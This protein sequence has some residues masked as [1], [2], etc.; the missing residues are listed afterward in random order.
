MN[1][2][3]IL[4]KQAL[5][6]ARQIEV[7]S[8][9]SI[10][11]PS[12]TH[13]PEY[14]ENVKKALSAQDVRAHSVK[15]LGTV[16]IAAAIIIATLVTLVACIKPLRNFVIEQFE[17]FARI[18]VDDQG[19]TDPIQR[20]TIE[21]VYVPQGIPDDYVEISFEKDE[22][23]VVTAWTNDT[24]LIVFTQDPA[25]INGSITINTQGAEYKE[26]YV[27]GM[28]V[29]YSLKYEEYTVVWQYDGYVFSLS[30][31]ESFGWEKIEY[32]ITNLTVR[33]E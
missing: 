17:K 23:Y 31:P 26:L 33:E 24:G 18:T 30:C 5:C 11:M 14:E 19:E 7:N 12:V 25:G 15:R 21:S 8:I 4:I 29:V 32:M 2:D 27:D 20:N 13:S 9:D 1:N 16:L 6:I 28:Q 22:I 10:P 3:I